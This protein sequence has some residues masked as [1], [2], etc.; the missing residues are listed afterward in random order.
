MC[1]GITFFA[2]PH[3]GSGILSKQE[4]SRAV[5]DSL[6]L[7]WEMSSV[8]RSEVSRE[9]Q[10][11]ELLNHEFGSRALGIPIWNY[12][13]TIESQ[14]KVLTD[15]DGEMLTK[16]KMRVVDAQSAEISN[17]LMNSLMEVEEVQEAFQYQRRFAC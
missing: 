7:K 16:V 6:H 10:K 17:G 8:L 12:I 1:I 3:R 2:T 14:L 5:Q 9:N 4:F 11:L 15:S 13:E